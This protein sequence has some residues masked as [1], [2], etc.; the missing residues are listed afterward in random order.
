VSSTASGVAPRPIAAA[1]GVIGAIG[2]AAFVGGGGVTVVDVE[3]ESPQLNSK[4]TDP[5]RR[6]R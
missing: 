3:C 6:G 4:A 1:S 2:T 5:K